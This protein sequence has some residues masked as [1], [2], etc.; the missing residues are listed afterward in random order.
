MGRARARRRAR[1][2]LSSPRFLITRWRTPG[3]SGRA[4]LS[5]QSQTLTVPLD[6]AALLQVARE[7]LAADA[8]LRD[9]AAD[10]SGHRATARSIPFSNRSS[11]W[12][13]TP[14]ARFGRGA[15]NPRGWL[16]ELFCRLDLPFIGGPRREVSIDIVDAGAGRSTI[17]V[18][19]RFRTWLPIVDSFATNRLAV[20]AIADEIATR[21]PEL[22]AERRA[23]DE[24]AQ[25]ESRL[26]DARLQVLRAQIEPHFLYN[27]L[28]NVQYLIRNDTVIGG[29][30]GRRAHR[31]PAAIA[32]EDAR[33]DLD[34]R[35]RAVARPRV[36]QR[37]AHPDGR[38]AVDRDRRA[39]SAAS[40]IPFRR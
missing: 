29:H 23:A 38:P 31:L 24:R 21:V 16:R 35:R 15:P 32:A 7:V 36:S 22:V 37:D 18:R 3:L 27:T 33:H 39:A 34:R 14:S 4:I 11:W 30:D 10:P 13:A 6:A 28:A 12:A 25:L 40:I 26:T 2:V 17:T 5:D 9:V 20:M 8:T 1:R 19:S